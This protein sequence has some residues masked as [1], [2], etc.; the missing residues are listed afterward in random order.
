MGK[1]QID[2]SKVDMWDETIWISISDTDH[3]EYINRG[4]LDQY[5]PCDTSLDN[6]KSG[7]I[8]SGLATLKIQCDECAEIFDLEYVYARTANNEDGE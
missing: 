1:E 2:L 8:E 3:D 7:T 6:I 4:D 5:H